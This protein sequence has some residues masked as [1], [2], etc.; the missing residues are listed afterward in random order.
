MSFYNNKAGFDGNDGRIDV[1][2]NK[3]ENLQPNKLIEDQVKFQANG[4]LTT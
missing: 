1:K 2:E 3:E 4:G